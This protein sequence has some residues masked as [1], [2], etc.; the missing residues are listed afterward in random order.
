MAQRTP[1]IDDIRALI[2]SDGA[3]EYWY[4]ALEGS[5]VKDRPVGLKIVGVDLVFFRGKD[6]NVA[7]L[8]NVCPHRGGSLMHGDCHFEGTVSC[9]YHGWTFDGDG[10]VL[11]VLP[12]GPD[13]RI[14]GKVAAR[15][16][17]TVTLK[18]MV[19]VWMGEGE[20]APLTEDIPPE[21]FDSVTSLLY[22]TELWPV[23][24]NVALENGL[25]AHFPYVHRNSLK[26]LA[27]PPDVLRSPR[28][29]KVTNGRS[30][31]A[32]APAGQQ[33]VST[34]GYVRHYY[35]ALNAYWP[36]HRRRLLWSWI[37]ALFKRPRLERVASWNHPDEEWRMG[38]HLPCIWRGGDFTRFSVPVTESTSRE[39][40]VI[41]SKSNSWL[42]RT[43]KRLFFNLWERR[44]L[45]TN[46]STQDFR[47]VSTQRYDTPEHLSA[48]DSPV[49]A[50]RRLLIQSRGLMTPKAAESVPDTQAEAF[51]F[52]REAEVGLVS[53]A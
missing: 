25:D 27:Y 39:V 19:F 42:G 5:K 30:V 11:A 12:E 36:K 23:N 17:P 52:E 3:K 16:Y 50:W 51:S 29:G 53:D 41:L 2:P 44:Y 22:T 9:P 28:R 49:V 43:Y 18:G 31:S 45:I 40:Y 7:A 48:T 26:L 47:A 20:P 13:S 1:A 32:V 6:G 35:P 8:W 15:K 37:F 10:N 14:P 46:F 38:H 21:F 34:A 4:P 24:W 33:R